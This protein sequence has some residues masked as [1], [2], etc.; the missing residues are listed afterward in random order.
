MYFSENANG[1]NVGDLVSDE[2]ILVDNLNLD[3][4]V[5]N[6]EV[7]VNIVHPIPNIFLLYGYGASDGDTITMNLNQFQDSNG[8]VLS[9]TL[10][11]TKAGGNWIPSV[12]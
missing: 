4:N 7:I 10:V 2:E 11:I 9:G 3:V 8:T 1:V 12:R 6:P 5:S